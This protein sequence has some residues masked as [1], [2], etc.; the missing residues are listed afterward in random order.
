MDHPL[1]CG[2]FS[3]L[4]VCLSNSYLAKCL[5]RA[6]KKKLRDKAALKSRKS[7]KKANSDPSHYRLRSGWVKKVSCPRAVRSKT[8]ARELR[9]ASNAWIGVREAIIEH[10][11]TL[12]ELLKDRYELVSWDGQYVDSLPIFLLSLTYVPIV[13]VLSL[14]T[15]MTESLALWL[16]PREIKKISRR[17]LARSKPSWTSPRRQSRLGHAVRARIRCGTTSAESVVNVAESS[18]LFPLASPMAGVRL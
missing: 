7:R 10:S 4:V 11:P 1:V 6:E 17:L 14:L 9:A 3:F 13:S 16:A 5:T 8:S 12:A 18:A 15:Q 2:F